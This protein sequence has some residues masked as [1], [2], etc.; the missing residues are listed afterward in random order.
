MDKFFFEVRKNVYLPP[1]HQQT[2][3]QAQANKELNKHFQSVAVY[4]QNSKIKEI[5]IEELLSFNPELRDLQMPLYLRS[6]DLKPD[7]SHQKAVG[8]PIPLILRGSSGSFS[9]PLRGPADCKTASN[10][11]R[12]RI[13]VSCL[14]LYELW[15]QQQFNAKIA[16]L[17]R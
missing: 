15:R 12:E 14:F 2:F 9:G 7:K 13:P 3:K 6:L 11:L 5:L 17:I 10:N 8:Y 4:G 1:E 16:D